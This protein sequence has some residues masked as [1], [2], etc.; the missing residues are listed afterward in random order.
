MQFQVIMRETRAGNLRVTVRDEHGHSICD[1]TVHDTHFTLGTD[2]KQ[3]SG[4]MP[5]GGAPQG[6]NRIRFE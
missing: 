5:A 3:T 1:L 6:W 4:R 2:R